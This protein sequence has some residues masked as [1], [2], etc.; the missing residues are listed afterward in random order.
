ML[1]KK[2]TKK[3]SKTFQWEGS[4]FKTHKGRWLWRHTRL[5][6]SCWSWRKFCTWGGTRRQKNWTS[7]FSMWDEFH[8]WSIGSRVVPT[9]AWKRFARRRGWCSGRSGRWRPRGQGGR[10][11]RCSLRSFL[12]SLW[13]PV[14]TWR[15]AY[16]TLHCPCCGWLWG[17]CSTRKHQVHSGGSTWR[18]LS[19]LWIVRNLF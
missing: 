9:S 13:Q 11:W 14:W 6:S 2:E 10:R 4:E 15:C 3:Y 16:Q 17:G 7:S 1:K 5:S 18:E 12:G 19:W 8:A